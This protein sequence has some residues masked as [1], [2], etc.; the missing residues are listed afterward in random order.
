M[1]VSASKLGLGVAVL[2]AIA[3]HSL[4]ALAGAP[5]TPSGTAATASATNTGTQTDTPTDTATH[6]HTATHIS[7]ATDTPLGT[8]ADTPVDMTPTA[9]PTGT[10]ATE[11]PTSSATATLRTATPTPPFPTDTPTATTTGTDA[12]PVT[13]TDAPTLASSTPSAT[14]TPSQPSVTPTPTEVPQVRVVIG[15]VAGAPGETV[16]LTVRLDA[17]AP[18]SSVSTIFGFPVYAPVV[19]NIGGL[20]SCTAA[21]EIDDDEVSFGYTFVV[22]DPT[23][24]YCT[25]GVAAMLNTRSPI[26]DG[27]EIFTCALRID[28]DAPTGRRDLTC[29]NASARG[30]SDD[31][32]FE[33]ACIDGSIEIIAASTATPTQAP[34][35]ITSTSPP[36]STPTPADS[37]TLRPIAADDDGC[38]TTAPGVDHGLAWLA[39]L[40][41][42]LWRRR[43]LASDKRSSC[44]ETPRG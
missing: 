42:L 26:A 41:A 17:A 28:D 38:Q 33:A 1:M 6:T 35:T 29:R 40:P 19:A 27:V 20:P 44:A 25:G 16:D 3:A 7:P 23:Q 5:T 36:I 14:P 31:F 9:L 4:P 12:G 11:S 37:P 34:P 24:G 15:S 21:A 22:C 39:P 2:L 13:P 10:A 30:P 8:P 32:E 43:R 18:V